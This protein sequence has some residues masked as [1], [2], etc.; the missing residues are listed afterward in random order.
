MHIL[1]GITLVSFILL[2]LRGA[3]RGLSGEL[4]HLVGLCAC[5]GTIWM[6]FDPVQRSFAFIP[7]LDGRSTTFY[8]TLFIFLVGAIVF[9][10]VAKLINRIGELIIPQPFNAIFGA[11]IGGA[12]ALLFISIIAGTIMLIHDKVKSIERHDAE[13][14]A[15]KILFECWD[16]IIFPGLTFGATAHEAITP[17]TGT[18][19]S[20]GGH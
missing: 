15:S 16:T 6:G 9:F 14:P 19:K 10:I 8:A 3:Y 5:I 12:K 13:A 20:N 2:V 7:Q 18:E 11:L 1:A 17:P 4:A